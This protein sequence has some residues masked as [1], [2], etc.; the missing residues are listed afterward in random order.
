MQSTELGR[1]QGAAIHDRPGLPSTRATD[2]Q[3][4]HADA[5]P[6]TVPRGRG[7]S[8]AFGPTEV[9]WN[10]AHQGPMRLL[11]VPLRW[12]LAGAS[13]VL[14]VA[15]SLASVAAYDEGVSGLQLAVMLATVLLASLLVN[16][17]LVRLALLPLRNLESTASRVWHGEFEARVPRSPLADR[18]M[19]RVAGAINLLLDHLIADR[20]RI[21]Q[22]AAQVIQAADRERAR[23]ARELHESTAQTLS[24]LALQAT[25][26]LRTA[27]DPEL[28]G[29]LQ[30]LR[31][32]AVDAL[33]EVRTLSHTVHPR[34]LDDLG[35][36]AALEWL[37][38]RTREEQRAD[39]T[40]ELGG[41]T[42]AIPRTLGSVL[43]SVAQEAVSNAVRHASARSIAIT[44]AADAR[45][46]RLN[47]VDDGRGFDAAEAKARRPGMGLF[48][49][50][51]RVALVDGAVEI[52]SAPG[53]GTRVTATIPITASH[54]YEQ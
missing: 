18:D 36:A 34:V 53:R 17:I 37:A 42:A 22:L 33:D 54:E 41:E 23:I 24:A 6:L 5:A 1:A 35:V 32:L 38:R 26:A 52:E 30:L 45:T 15:A 10:S 20:T 16:L 9:P 12:K 7:T 29:K 40:V 21:R 19:T 14:V 48:A 44:L 49:M 50:S 27:N 13:G 43:Y 28:E 2:P 11:R 8:E 51:E 25:T 39:T 47:I 31:D 46:A 3:D 4:T